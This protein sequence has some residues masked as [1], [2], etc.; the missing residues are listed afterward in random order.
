MVRL[1]IGAV[2]LYW[3]Q[4]W[5]GVTGLV[6]LGGALAALSA[7]GALW[8]MAAAL[9]VRG[10]PSEAHVDRLILVACLVQGALQIVVASSWHGYVSDELAFD[11][12]AASALIHGLNPYGLNLASALRQ[13]GVAWG[14]LTLGGQV[15]HTVSYPSLSFLLYVPAT[16]LFGTGSGAGLGTDALAWVIGGALLW[17]MVDPSLRP[18]VA[19]FLILPIP[20]LLVAEGATDPL[21]LPFLLVAVWRWDRFGDPAE[22]SPAR[23]VGPVALGLACCVKQTPWL[24]APFLIAAVGI[25]AHHRGRVWLEAC[26]RYVLIA[27]A[28]FL[29]P[30]LAFMVWN[31]GAWLT[32]VLVPL[33]TALV[34]LGIGPAELVGAYG[35]GGGDMGLFGWSGAALTVAALLILIWRYGRLKPILPLL[36]LLGVLLETRSLMSYFVFAI[37]VLVIAATTVRAVRWEPPGR[38]LARGLTW[39]GGVLA[40][41]AAGLLVAALADPPPLAITVQSA[42]VGASRLVADVSVSNRGGQPVRVHFILAV[43]GTSEQVMSVTSGPAVLDAGQRASYALVATD[44]TPLP[45]PGYPFQF[46]LTSTDP[47]MLAVTPQLTSDAAGDVSP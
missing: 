15:V 20:L 42:H 3:A 38:R 8:I 6:P 24:L 18:G 25:E 29:V 37:P 22:R 33:R 35:L 31:P 14:T 43:T 19:L 12:A 4:A 41:A 1:L 11:Q 40:A 32:G 36:P 46:Q 5:I 10:H 23:W 27:G 44:Q 39:G 17:R 34:P 30:N 16:L 9:T 28:A 26:G 21:Y 47:A 2:W 45:T 7:V 13:Y